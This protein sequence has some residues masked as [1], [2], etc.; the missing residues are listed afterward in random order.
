LGLRISFLRLYLLWGNI[1]LG[2]LIR[3]LASCGTNEHAQDSSR[4]RLIEQDV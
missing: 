1:F 2:L 3:F 4:Q